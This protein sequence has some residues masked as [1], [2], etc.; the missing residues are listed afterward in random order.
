VAGPFGDDQFGFIM[1]IIDKVLVFIHTPY[2]DNKVQMGSRGKESS[3][4]G[5]FTETDLQ[6]N[7]YESKGLWSLDVANRWAPMLRDSSYMV[8]QQN[9]DILRSC[10]LQAIMLESVV[11]D[12]EIA[13]KGSICT[14][15]EKAESERRLTMVCF[16][17][18]YC[19][20]NSCRAATS[21]SIS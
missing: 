3:Y 20:S 17:S 19:L 11:L 10:N 16:S 7:F 1:H 6:G 18:C 5:L 2:E 13:W 4:S 14:D 9:Q 21:D 15:R 8:D 12:P